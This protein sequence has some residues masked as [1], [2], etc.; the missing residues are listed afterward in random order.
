MSV[1]FLMANG[2]EEAEEVV[3]ADLLRRAGADVKLALVADNASGPAAVTGSHGLMLLTDMLADNIDVK[4]ADAIVLPGGTAGTAVL[5]ASDTVLSLIEQAAS[6]GRYICAICAA[7]SILGSMKLL[8]G[9]KATCYPS[10]SKYLTGSIYTGA[11]V[12]KDD[13]FITAKAAGAA[14]S[15]GLK[16][17]ETLYGTAVSDKIKGEIFY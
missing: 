4:T 7:P 10:F 8:E 12:E 1:Y 5:A 16:I 11:D 17:V 14:F 9:R 6:N 2:F 15:F 3:P 13:I